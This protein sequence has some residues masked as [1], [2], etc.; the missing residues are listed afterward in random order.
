[1]KKTFEKCWMVLPNRQIG[2]GDLEVENGTI[3]AVDLQ[4][5]PL[6]AWSFPASSTAT[7]IPP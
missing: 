7:V 2:F 1:M 5:Q 6:L 4:P 3:T